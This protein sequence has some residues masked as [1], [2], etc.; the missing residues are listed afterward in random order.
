MGRRVGLILNDQGDELVD[1]RLAEAG[2]FAAEEIT[3]GCFCCRFT[4]FMAAAERFLKAGAPEFIF[5][6]PVGSC[7]DLSATILQPL[8]R[9][10]AG[11]FRIAPLTVLVDPSRAEQ[12]L[13]S[14]AD[15]LT[16]YLFQKQLAEADLV[17]FSK[18]DLYDRFPTLAGID[19]RSL[20]ARTGAG[21]GEWLDELLSDRITAGSR[22]LDIDY[23]RYAE[24][25]AGL[26]WLNW[27]A[28]VRLPSA[29]TPAALTGPL[30]TCLD[31][32]LTEAR[33]TIGH[34]KVFTESSTGYVKASIC[35]NGDRPSVEGSLDAPPA[36]R[37]TVTVNLRAAAP[38]SLLETLVKGAIEHMPG[39]VRIVHQQAFRPARPEPEHRF[40]E[41]V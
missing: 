5:A 22:L 19:A 17:Y 30:M 38:P 25:E 28:D 8:K 7:T 2:G 35:R 3:G 26:G 23:D 13:A 18:A 16:S 9:Y 33:A 31:Q 15:P 39:R 6:E 14:D 40:E 12:L 36:N 1:T 4:E 29:L 24:A 20:S 21:V 41:V 11:Q 27:R 10:Y 32:G 37:H 34:L